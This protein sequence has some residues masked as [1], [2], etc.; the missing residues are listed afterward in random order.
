MHQDLKQGEIA[1]RTL[2]QNNALHL[3]LRRVSQVLND[4]GYSVEQVLTYFSMELSWSPELCKEI[5]W[6]TAQKRMLGKVSTTQLFK[7]GE[8]DDI[9]DVVTRFLGE[10][11]KIEN[12]PPFPSLEIDSLTKALK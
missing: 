8:I 6:R 7:Q 4:A 12:P 5:L 1:K 9:V 3:Y 10:R 2:A 11:L